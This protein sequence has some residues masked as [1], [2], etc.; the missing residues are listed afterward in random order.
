MHLLRPVELAF[1]T[2]SRDE[3]GVDGELLAGPATREEL[4]KDREVRKAWDQLLYPHHDH[5]DRRHARH[6]PPV[7]LIG[8]G[9]DR[10]RLG[11]PEVRPGHA[12]IRGQELLPQ[13]F[14]GESRQVLDVRG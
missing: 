14:A 12:D 7:A 4:D 1:A 11:D 8:Y 3:V 5:V 2:R 9:A 6:Q 13:P 10:A